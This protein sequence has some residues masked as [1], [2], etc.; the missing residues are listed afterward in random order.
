[1]TSN[2]D[3]NNLN[4]NEYSFFFRNCIVIKKKYK[5]F[6]I[7]LNNMLEENSFKI[8]GFE[9]KDEIIILLS[10]TDEE[11]MLK[12]AQSSKLKKK[13]TNRSP[14]ILQQYTELN[15]NEKIIEN[16]ARR[17]FVLKEKDNFV[18][19]S[20][21]DLLH[22]KKSE[23]RWGLGL[24]TESEMLFIEYKILTEIKVDQNFL[25][26]IPGTVLESKL[27]D[28]RKTMIN[29]K[30][31][32]H[33]F[34]QFKIIKTH[35]PLHVSDFKEHIFNTTV[36]SVRCPYRTI[37]SY[38]GDKV[39]VYY[40]WIYHYTRF[41]TI[42]SI[43]GLIVITMNLYFADYSKYVL[44]LYA[45]AVVIWAQL[46]S[47]Y[48]KRKCSEISIE[49][50]NYSHEY[51]KENTRREFKGT[52]RK[53]PITNQYEKYYSNNKR[54]FLYLVS[55]SVIMPFIC[56]SLLLNII[57][58]NL[59]GF[60]KPNLN[61]AFELPFFGIYAQNGNLFDPNGRLNIFIPIIQS[62]VISWVY[63]VYSR[64]A[65]K[66]CN[67]EN[68]RLKSNYENSLIIKKYAFIFFDSFVSLFYLAF[69]LHDI[70]ALKSQLVSY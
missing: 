27:E 69:F 60:I 12:V 42:P 55:V 5:P 24:F 31:L 46:F 61:S 51:E 59:S 50:D 40:A 23:E 54:K 6:A 9:E 25:D 14:E 58:F 8:K 35:F 64:L 15:L 21:Y 7:Y 29:E 56:L 48:W 44:T 22:D 66:T 13:Y 45:I 52:W 47:I 62:I 53:S 57:F 63:S 18:A 65:V 16:E 10:Q 41:L 1:M 39:G 38:F 2:L 3:A 33:L 11:K 26:L 4:S 17:S 67:W 37:R 19:D 43:L 68:H 34:N 20:N 49:W 32:F 28:I 36:K 30:S 70:T